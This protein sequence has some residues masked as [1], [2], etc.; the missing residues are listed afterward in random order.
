MHWQKE[1]SRASSTTNQTGS[2]YNNT[3]STSHVDV[4]AALVMLGTGMMLACSGWSLPV[5]L[6]PGA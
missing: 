2:E 3:V 1:S 5:Q 4:Y 6:Y